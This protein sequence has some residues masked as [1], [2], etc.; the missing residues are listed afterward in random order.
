MNNIQ[1]ALSLRTEQGFIQAE[2]QVW[3]AQDTGC[4]GGP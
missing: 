1:F 4:T 2:N 3:Q